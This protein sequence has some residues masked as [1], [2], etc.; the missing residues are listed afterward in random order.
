MIKRI[1]VKELFL[2]IDF[3]EEFGMKILF[4]T[5]GNH[6]ATQGGIQTFNRVMKKFFPEE[7]CTLTKKLKSKYEKLYKIED[8]IEVGSNKKFFISINKRLKNKIYLYLFY[9]KI[10]EISPEICILNSPEELQYLK[11]FPNIKKILVQHT[12]FNRYLQVYFKNDKNLI[13]KAKKELD[14]FVFLSYYDKIKFI[15]ELNFPE[16]KAVVIRHTCELEI[17]NCCKLKNKKLIMISRLDNK[18]KRFDLIIKAMKSLRDFS[19]NIYGDGA[20][21]KYLENLI[22]E[23]RLQNVFLCG[24]TKQVAEK[25]DENGIFIMASDFEGYGITNIEAMRRGL[26][27]ILRNTFESAKDI[28][29]ENGILLGKEWNEDEFIKAVRKVYN[30]YDFYS[31]NS[32]EKAKNYDFD[33]IKNQWKELFKMK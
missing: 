27:I 11:K 22:E 10:L 16:K 25:L 29:E 30:D 5:E 1:G 8:V 26:P 2:I 9:K 13:E 28:I 6:P 19:L 24:A 31:K 4:L 14:Y 32:L 21:K 33:I 18:V 23:N 12:S 7:L 20:D 3:K 15:K 17:L